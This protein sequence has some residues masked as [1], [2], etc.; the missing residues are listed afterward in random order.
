[1]DEFPL[2][3]LG[4][5]D[6]YESWSQYKGYVW[7]GWTTRKAQPMHI[8]SALQA[9]IN[10]SEQVAPRA[11]DQTY[12]GKDPVVVDSTTESKGSQLPAWD[13]QIPVSNFSA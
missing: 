7:S 4:L 8:D 2:H 6:D 13:D 3:G 10:Q 12:A 11:A 9:L 1:M 5:C